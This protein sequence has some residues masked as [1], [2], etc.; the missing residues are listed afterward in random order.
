[1]EVKSSKD[2]IAHTT[3]KADV[4]EGEKNTMLLR[5]IHVDKE[6]VLLRAKK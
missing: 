5:N 6:L 2:S 3:V 1:M 4:M